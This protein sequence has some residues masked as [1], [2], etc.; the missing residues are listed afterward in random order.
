[1]VGLDDLK[2]LFQPKSFHDSMISELIPGKMPC[3][4]QNSSSFQKSPQPLNNKRRKC[5]K[6]KRREKISHKIRSSPCFL[7]ALISRNPSWLF[8]TFPSIPQEG[9]LPC[10][11]SFLGFLGSLLPFLSRLC[12]RLSL[13]SDFPSE[14]LGRGSSDWEWEG[15]A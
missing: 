10:F 15:R 3:F 9:L 7:L 8:T 4:L 2:G 6:S 1:M 14:K 5:Q 13:E 12:L 11:P